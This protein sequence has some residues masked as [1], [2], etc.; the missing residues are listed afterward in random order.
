MHDQIG[1]TKS[2]EDCADPSR[3][4]QMVERKRE[5]ERER[6]RERDEFLIR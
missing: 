2:K 4:I 5:R 3:N 6:K 1:S